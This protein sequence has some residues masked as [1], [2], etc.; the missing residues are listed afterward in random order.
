M[1]G[2]LAEFLPQYITKSKKSGPTM[3]LDQW[4]S[5]A[6]IGA[7][8]RSFLLKNRELIGDI[9]SPNLADHLQDEEL[10]RGPTGALR[11]FALLSFVI[12]GK[13]NI[14]SSVGAYMPSFTELANG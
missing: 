13:V 3:P 14:E 10:Y 12:W 8:S 9:L 11:L 2:M 5:N 4:F 7:T 6:Q 1:R